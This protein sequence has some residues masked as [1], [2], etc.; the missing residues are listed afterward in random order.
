MK[1]K[2]VLICGYY[3]ESNGKDYIVE[4]DTKKLKKWIEQERND[5]QNFETKMEKKIEVYNLLEKELTKDIKCYEN[6]TVNF[7]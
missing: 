6:F 1:L 3:D 2:E 7:K 5:L 4:V